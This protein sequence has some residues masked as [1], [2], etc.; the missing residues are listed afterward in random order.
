[1]IILALDTATPV[2]SVALLDDGE[3]LGQVSEP[4]KNHSRATLIAIDRLVNGLGLVRQDLGGI[5]VGIGPGSFTGV[6]VGLTLA[7]SLSFAL[8]IPLVG[9]STL[10]ALAQNGKSQ[11][12]EWICPSLDALKNEVYGACFQEQQGS[13]SVVQVEAARDPRNW[14]NE[15]SKGGKKCLLLGSGFKR[16]SKVFEDQLGSSAIAVAQEGLHVISAAA[17]GLLASERLQT[18]AGDDPHKLEPMYCRLSEAELVH[19]SKI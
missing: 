6:R 9:I 10:R 5:A 13:L 8:R 16:Y 17:I 15:L 3:L 7:K 18:G 12:A 1:V 2:T 11:G 19:N 4:S 14:A